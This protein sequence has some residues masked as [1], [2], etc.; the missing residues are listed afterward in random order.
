V[1]EK[2]RFPIFPA[3]SAVSI[4]AMIMVEKVE[5]KRRNSSTRRNMRPPR[6]WTWPAGMAFL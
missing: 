4:A 5:V 6:S 3:V 1:R 2:S